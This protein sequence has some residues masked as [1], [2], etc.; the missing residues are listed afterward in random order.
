[1]LSRVGFRFSSV[2]ASKLFLRHLTK[3]ATVPVK[4]S[5]GCMEFGRQ[6]PA[7]QAKE[8]V[9]ISME[10]GVY[11][12]DTAY[13]YSDGKSEEIMGEIDRLKD[14]KVFIATK[15]NPNAGGE[16]GQGLKYDKVLEQLNESLKRLKKD[17]VDLFYLHSPSHK[18]PIEETLQAVNHLYKVTCSKSVNESRMNSNWFEFVR[19]I[20]VTKFC[21]SDIDCRKNAPCYTRQ[22]VAA[23]C[24]CN[25]MHRLVTSSVP[26]FKEGIC[27]S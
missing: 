4:T 3:M 13:L 9:N 24:R 20:A 11:E 5:I 8:F 2:A 27:I 22:H 19:L 10:N 7:D 15:A 6:C 1:M 23:T 14:P 21:R 12:F 26:T 18:T 25:I 16:K 17:S